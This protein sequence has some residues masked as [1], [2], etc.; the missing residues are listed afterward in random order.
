MAIIGDSTVCDYPL[1]TPS[2]GWG[3]F[4]AGYFDDS[5]KVV[6]LAASGRSTKTFIKEGLWQ[7]TLDGKPTHVL[8]QFGHNDMPGKG[9]NRETDPKTPSTRLTKLGEEAKKLAES[10]R[11]EIKTLAKCLHKELEWIPLKAMRKEPSLRYASV[12]Q[13]AADVERYLN[14][15]EVSARQGNFRYRIGKLLR[16]HRTGITVGAMFATVLI[17]GTVVATREAILA[18]RAQR[19][20]EDQSDGGDRFA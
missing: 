2:R 16:R 10:R 18:E 17:G 15:W 6:N 13:L 7:K 1:D 20:A 19:R 11:T 14:G 3:M 12:E 4:I 5:V 8:I 9:P